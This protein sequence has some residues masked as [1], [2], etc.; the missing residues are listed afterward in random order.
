MAYA[1]A[2]VAGSCA[3]CEGWRMNTYE[4]V[5][6][7]GCGEEF[8]PS[9]IEWSAWQ[10]AGWGRVRRLSVPLMGETP[11]CG[12]YVYEHDVAL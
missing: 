3:A 1:W 5:P 12:L 10:D 6:C 8:D 11:C 2:G 4:I 7:P 9:A